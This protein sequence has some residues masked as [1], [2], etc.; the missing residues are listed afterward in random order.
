MFTKEQLKEKFEQ[1]ADIPERNYYIDLNTLSKYLKTWKIDP[2]YEDEDKTEYFDESAVL[3]LNRGIELKEQGISDD[4]ILLMLSTE[5][6]NHIKLSELKHTEIAS[7]DNMNGAEIK[8][9]TVDVTSH[10]I[11]VLADTLAQKISKDITDKLQSSDLLEP[12]LES[13][14]LRRDNEVLAAQIEKLLEENKKLISK[15]NY[16]QRENAKYTHLF[17]TLYVKQN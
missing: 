2:V 6:M 7:M 16:L 1:N 5:V 3:K 4:K 13:G 12:I 11:S 15:I 14:K 8:K 10:T 17:G 9:L